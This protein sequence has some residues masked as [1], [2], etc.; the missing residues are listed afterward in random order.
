MIFFAA[1]V[2]PLDSHWSAE[3]K[4]C[5][6]DYASKLYTYVEDSMLMST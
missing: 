2:L 4:H 1:G 6:L 5:S 3:L